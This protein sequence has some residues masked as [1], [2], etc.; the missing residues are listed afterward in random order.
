MSFVSDMKKHLRNVFKKSEVAAGKIIFQSM[1]GVMT[2]SPVLSGDFRASWF[3]TNG[4]PS[5][6]QGPENKEPGATNFQAHNAEQLSKVGELSARFMHPGGDVFITNNK[7]YGTRLEYGW[8]KKAPNG[9]VRI[10]A[11]D[12]ATRNESVKLG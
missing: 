10:T 12:V 4:S 11:Q 1:Q 3:P 5:T 7:P 9:M 6:N 2:R 8:S